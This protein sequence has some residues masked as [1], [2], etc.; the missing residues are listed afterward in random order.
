MKKLMM[1][2]VA[3]AGLMA[4][5]AVHAN[6]TTAGDHLRD[7]A[8]AADK[9]ADA[10]AAEVKA[11]AAVNAEQAKADAEGAAAASATTVTDTVKHRAKQAGHKVKQAGK[12]VSEKYNGAVAEHEAN[13]AAADVS[14]S[15]NAQ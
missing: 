11:G 15:L 2:S 3:A 14:A 8:Q 5:S 7:A 1:L 9:A 10:K 4:A 6:D 12:K 13:K